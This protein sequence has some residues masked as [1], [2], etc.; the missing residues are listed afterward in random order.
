MLNEFKA[1]IARGNVM[2]L[3]VGVI[4]GGAFG[5]I[6]KSLVDDL[7]M[8]IVGAIFGGFD[9]SNYFLPLSSAVNAPTL[10]AARAQGAVFAYGSFLTVLI[11]FLILAWIIFLMVKGV[12]YLRMQVERQEKAAPEELPPPPADVLLLTEI[13]DLLAKRPAV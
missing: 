6:V 8:P 11:N 9:F 3:A 7:I 1:F 12:N 10:A 5:G 13:R 2:D 4:I